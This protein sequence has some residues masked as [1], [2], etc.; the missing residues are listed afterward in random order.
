MA[1]IR[2]RLARFV[3]IV[4]AAGLTSL[5]SATA[6]TA[7]PGPTNLR[8][9]DI[10]ASS[11]TLSWKAPADTTNVYGYTIRNLLASATNNEVGSSL[12]TTGTAQLQPQTSYKLVVYASY[13][14]TTVDSQPSNAV[15]FTTPADTTAPTAPTLAS[16]WHTSTSIALSWSGASDDVGVESF[17]ISDGSQ[18]WE[19]SAPDLAWQ[20]TLSGLATNRTYTLTVRAR[21]AAGNLSPPSNAVSV[22]IENQPPTA[23][24]NLRVEDGRLV[25]DRSTDNSGTIAGY[26]VYFD[27]SNS[28]RGTSGETSV[29]LE[30][31]CDPMF[32]E[33]FPSS[34]THTF[35]VKGRDPSGNVSSESNAVTAVIP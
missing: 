24:T 17:Q 32:D 34:G 18:T 33:C 25:W 15:T 1:G 13:T 22:L 2:A 27:G 28:Y 23:P 31:T 10:R 14:N 19:Q 8:V 11:A 4:V 20:R 5:S 3:L 30:Q 6:T 12:T 9:T 29:T 7:P 26:M 35:T 16:P 21:D